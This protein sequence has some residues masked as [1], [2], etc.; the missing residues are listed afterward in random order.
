[1]Y[2]YEIDGIIVTNNQI[3]PI[4]KEGSCC[5]ERIFGIY[6]LDKKINTLNL[7][8]FMNKI[9]GKRDYIWSEVVK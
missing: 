2:D 6:F 5:Y 1:M 7:H 8:D 9:H 3:P 4:N